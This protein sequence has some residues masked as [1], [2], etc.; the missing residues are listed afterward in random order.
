MK[1]RIRLVALCA[2]M[3]VLSGCFGSFLLVRNLYEFNAGIENEY[4]RS[5]LFWGL[6]IIPVYEFAAFGDAVVLNVIEFWSGKNPL[7]NTETAEGVQ[8]SRASRDVLRLRRLSPA[9]TV[10]ELEL[11]RVGE[12]AGLVR[13]ADGEVVSAAEM[14]GDGSI[15]LTSRGV[16]RVITV[17]E[18]RALERAATAGCLMS[19]ARDLLWGDKVVACRP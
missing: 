6:V 19:S 10:E 16:V 5:L 3:S 18:V 7:E 12:R 8:V 15:A 14:L 2:S 11:V 9:G 17:D 1:R 13:K 4:L